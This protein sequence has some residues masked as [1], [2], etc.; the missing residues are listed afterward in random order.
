MSSLALV[1]R[2]KCSSMQTHSSRPDLPMLRVVY[3]EVH[4]CAAADASGQY[5]PCGHCVHAPREAPPAS[6]LYVPAGHAISR[7]EIE[8]AGQ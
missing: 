6:S 5:A 2:K 4:D 1:M 3:S 7:G 8:P